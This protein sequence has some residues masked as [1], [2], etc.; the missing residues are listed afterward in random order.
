ML[1]PSET[2]TL[3]LSA[4][5]PEPRQVQGSVAVAEVLGSSAVATVEP[6][7]LR[8]KCGPE[9]GRGA[10]AVV[11]K[12]LSLDDGSIFVAKETRASPRNSDERRDLE[13]AEGELKILRDL[14]HPNIVSVLGHER[15]DSSFYIFLEYV[16]GGSMLEYLDNWGPL[17]D[18]LLRKASRGLLEGLDYMH[19]R[20]EPVM[21]RDMKC[22]NILVTADFCVKWS[23][24][25]HSKCD[26]NT[27]S[28]STV[29]S[30][31]WMAP[32][33]IRQEGEGYGRKADIWS[34][35]CVVVEMAS[36][37]RPWG[38]AF[39][40]ENGRNKCFLF[41][42][43]HIADSDATPAIPKDLARDGRE[44]A[45]SCLQRSPEARPWAS[46]LLRTSRFVRGPECG[47]GS[48]G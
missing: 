42:M 10:C 19:S 8:W 48:S 41:V 13:R 11:Y 16:S 26:A 27:R 21:H 24:F 47:E 46:E 28:T 32:E 44:L 17:E 33:V 6:S 15:R 18:G 14:R 3:T 40:D 20:P 12:A 25:G 4:S 5:D 31:P 43:K 2:A 22:A 37:E 35:G 9:I 39:L 36:A 34:F 29:G 1:Q 38:K 23:D 30:V 7:P 45:S